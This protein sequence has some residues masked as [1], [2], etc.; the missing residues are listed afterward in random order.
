[1][2]FLVFPHSV[3]ALNI[4]SSRAGRFEGL[5]PE[6]QAQVRRAGLAVCMFGSIDEGLEWCEDRTLKFRPA[7]PAYSV[8]CVVFWCVVKQEPV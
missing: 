6:L 3:K 4:L 2:A 7:G 8:W 5:S 1:M